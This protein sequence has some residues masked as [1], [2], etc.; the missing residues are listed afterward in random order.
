VSGA[1]GRA[2]CRAGRAAGAWGR[3]A[4]SACAL[5]LA[6]LAACAAAPADSPAPRERRAD[7]ARL[8][9]EL[10]SGKYPIGGPFTLTDPA[11]KRV[12]LADFKGKLVLLYF[13]YATCPDVCPTDLA[14]IGLA[15]R[16]LGAAAE[17]VQPIFVT[18]D[19]RRDTPAVL[20]EYATVFHPRFVSLTGSEEEVRRVATD[21]KVFFE[22]VPRPGTS[23]YAID[24]TA[25]T[26]LLDREGKFVIL[27][28]PGTEA[29]RMA[30]MLREQVATRESR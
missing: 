3:A 23:N 24:H 20:R 9:N 26:F 15:L 10:M 2:S 22:K 18:L 17:E 27:F 29:G 14:Q 30:E 5:A 16:A 1:R 12:A 6:V 19:P 4:L 25:Y 7:A 21:F 28:P 8:M 11:G 13:G